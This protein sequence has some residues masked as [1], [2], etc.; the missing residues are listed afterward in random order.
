MMPAP[1][2]QINP[3]HLNRSP[4]RWLRAGL[5][6]ALILCLAAYWMIIG[7]P[8]WRAYRHAHA[9]IADLEA[10]CA[11]SY[12]APACVALG[13]KQ[14]AAR[15]P[16]KAIAP[17]QA[18][19]NH[20]MTSDSNASPQDKAQVAGI[21]AE[22]LMLSGHSDDAPRYFRTAIELDN[23]NVPGHLA[24]ALWLQG[25]RND[26]LAL[27]EL[28]LVTT[29]DP[30]SD[31][32]WF[33][34]AHIKNANKE[35]DAARTAAQ[36]A[37]AINPV[38]PNYWQE[39]GDSYGYAG[40]Y[41]EAIAPYREELRL[42]PDSLAAQSDVARI[43]ALSANTPAEY[44]EALTRLT[45][46]IRRKNLETGPAYS[47]LGSLHLRFNH[48]PEARAALEKAVKY[49]S[50]I[51]EIYYNLAMACRLSGDQK[52]A[53]AAMKQFHEMETHFRHTSTLQKQLSEN[54]NDPDLHVE[55]AK[56]WEYYKLYPQALREYRAALHLRPG[57][58]VAAPK[59]REL[60]HVVPPKPATLQNWALLRL[61]RA[62]AGLTVEHGPQSEPE[63]SNP[64]LK[65][66][67]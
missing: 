1:S 36:K 65:N 8:R 53:D 14:V 49:D 50:T 37:I 32:A 56:E 58:P 34:L 15:F 17:L 28:N 16:Q 46:V 60:A 43:L 4:A 41:R 66:P 48:F 40:R 10:M 39:L 30:K 21:L 20:V 9:S 6:A 25:L 19:W 24:F 47:L 26:E 18:C 31:F 7:L 59:V 13:Q 22:A 51:P 42:D 45:D 64:A 63:A 38:A 5:F 29:V 62:N 2:E 54:V 61:L 27:N 11:Q 52:G 3:P 23:E 35:M 44:E 55:L 57:D 67:K 12:D 33:L